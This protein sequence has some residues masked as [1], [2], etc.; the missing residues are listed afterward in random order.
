MTANMVFN[1]V[2]EW[3]PPKDGKKTK[4]PIHTTFDQHHTE[5]TS[6]LSD[7]NNNT[8]NVYRLDRKKLDQYL[9]L[10]VKSSLQNIEENL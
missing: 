2:T 5:N 8:V 6:K 1:G 3:F 10:D 4:M 7:E 9:F